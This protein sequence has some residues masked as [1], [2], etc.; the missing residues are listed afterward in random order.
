MSNK[1][2][3]LDH[4]KFYISIH[5]SF[6]FLKLQTI[7]QLDANKNVK[8]EDFVGILGNFS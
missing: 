3:N 7:R 1:N 2:E 4:F 8:F 6:K 5:N